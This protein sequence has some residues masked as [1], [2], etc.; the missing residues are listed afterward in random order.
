MINIQKK[1][2]KLYRSLIRNLLYVTTSRPNI[3]QAVG[4][5]AI[6]QYALNGA[7]ASSKKNIKI[8]RGHIGIWL[9]V[10]KK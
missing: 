4:L 8:S 5:V 1:I 2:K 7:R 9:V 10:F 6:F 3:M